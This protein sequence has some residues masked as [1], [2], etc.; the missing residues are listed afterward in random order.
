[1][2]I[3]DAGSCTSSAMQEVTRKR[4]LCLD[5]ELPPKIRRFDNTITIDGESDFF[6]IIT[7]IFKN[8]ARK[9]V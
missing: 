3:A 1:M 7:T 6:L 5:E 8:F 2:N 9:K 4:I